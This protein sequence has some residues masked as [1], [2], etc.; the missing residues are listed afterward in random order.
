MNAPFSPI[1]LRNRRPDGP[2]PFDEYRAN[3]GYEALLATVG[4]RDPGEVQAMVLEANLRGRGGAGFPAGRKWQ[5]VPKGHKG[6][7]FVLPNTDEMEPGSFKDRI[8]VGADPHMVIEGVLLCAY[9]VGAEHGIFF[10]RPS[11]EM[12]AELMEREL[13]I[14]RSAGFLGRNILGSGF[15]FDM[16]V[17]RSA[18]RYICGEASAQINAISGLRPNP[19]KG[20]PRMAV[21]GLWGR[22]TVVNNVETLA[23]LPGIVQNGPQWFKNLA[24]TPTG[25]GSKLYSVCGP[26]ARPECYELPMGTP[27][28][29]ILFEHAGG[30]LPGRTF[31]ACLPGGASTSFL[32]ARHLDVPMDF[33]ALKAIGQRLGTGCIIVFDEETCLVGATLNMIDFFARES[34]GW[35][36]PCREGLPFI[37]NILYQI[38]SGQGREEHIG[39]LRQMGH[40]MR[41]AYCALA[42]GAAAPLL[43]LLDFFEDEVREHIRHRSC[44]FGAVAPTPRGKPCAPGPV[45]FGP[46]P[47]REGLS[48]RI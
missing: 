19:R 14:A 8:L 3:G 9:A 5:S 21:S 29:E 47:C 10:V 43:G 31:K 37:R 23:C 30:M 46:T 39:M 11:Y 36:T 17:H 20:G 41:H 18:G 6:P 7:K 26:V 12:D 4:K 33:D 45:T 35:C 22:P 13:E 42:P 24:R 15:D 2:V 34:C 32:P 48:C 38:E 28:R 40:H 16:V 44:P 27:L 1:L 25:S